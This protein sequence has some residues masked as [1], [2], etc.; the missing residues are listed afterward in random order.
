MWSSAP[1]VSCAVAGITSYSETRVR[2]SQG[3]T[4]VRCRT[5]DNDHHPKGVA[6]F[7]HRLGVTAPIS[8]IATVYSNLLMA[9]DTITVD[10]S[11][12]NR[13][14]AGVLPRICC[15]W[16][17]YVALATHNAVAG[18]QICADVCGYAGATP[19]TYRYVYTEIH[20]SGKLSVNHKCNWQY[21]YAQ[22]L[23]NTA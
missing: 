13:R 4:I 9:T 3:Q 14:N 18:R 2:N 1:A 19:P 6:Y 23:C 17:P 7:V 21:L 12:V 5:V 15:R 22:V 10:T 20:R 16:C 8:D 11:A